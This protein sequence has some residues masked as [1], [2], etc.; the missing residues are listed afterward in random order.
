[1]AGII[2]T[3]FTF[4]HE[5]CLDQI[6][7]SGIPCV[8]IWEKLENPGVNYV[9]FDNYKAAYSMT[10]YLINLNHR[11]IGLIIGPFSKVGRVLKRYEGFLDAL[12]AN[13]ISCNPDWII[14][15][16]PSL[17]EG[18]ESMS[19]LMKLK[20]R[21]SAVFA[22]SDILAIGA[23]AGARDAGLKVPEDVSLCGFDDVDFASYCYPSLTTVHVPGYEIG[24]KAVDIILKM[25]KQKIFKPQHYCFDT[26][27][28]VRASCRVFNPGI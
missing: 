18:R 15:C 25:N 14:E 28:V 21:P 16:E 12:N 3:G 10:E 22:A 7:H 1:L 11:R 19:Y 26:Q 5:G 23:L 2:V 4:G 24:Q 8:V 20:E 13:R 9:G 17:I 6:I 27:I